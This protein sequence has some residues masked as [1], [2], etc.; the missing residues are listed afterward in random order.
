MATDSKESL[1]PKS[2]P[3]AEENPLAPIPSMLPA[4]LAD[5]SLRE[6]L[7]MLLSSVGL[8]ER[9][10]YL[11]RAVEDPPNYFYERSL[12]LGAPC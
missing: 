1:A 11:E 4:N 3:T 8:A 6:L 5:L 12:N 9:K 2:L 10:T 7:S